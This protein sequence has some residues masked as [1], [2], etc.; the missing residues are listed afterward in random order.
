MR[1]RDALRRGQEMLHHIE[2]PRLSSEILLSHVLAC[3]RMRLLL[4][5]DHTLSREEEEKFFSFI[6]KRARDVPISYLTGK[7]EFYGLDF[8]V[9]SSTLIPRP[10]T[11][12]VVDLALQ[13]ANEKS[14]LLFADLGSGSGNIA[15]SILHYRPKWHAFLV[16]KNIR[17][18]R[19]AQKNAAS[20]NS[21]LAFFLNADFADL[22]FQ[23][24]VLDLIVANPPYIAEQEK[25]LVQENVLRYEPHEALFAEKNGLADLEAIIHEAE[26]VLC[27]PSTLILEHGACQG[28][29]VRRLLEEAHFSARTYCDLAGLER[30]TLGERG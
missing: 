29:D 17:A 8:S 15:L 6:Q 10:E 14:S 4:M 3:P 7:K 5:D 16:E 20:L 13:L 28:K 2:S 24:H 22:P 27:T 11:E 12:L 30:V 19:I 25:A 26:R 18:H 9:D 21:P 23:D 1:I